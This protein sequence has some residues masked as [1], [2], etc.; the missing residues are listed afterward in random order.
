M[1]NILYGENESVSRSFQS[2]AAL[3]FAGAF[4]KSFIPA[5]NKK[6]LQS[7][8]SRKA[9]EYGFYRNVGNNKFLQNF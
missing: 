7:D 3:G 8:M 9:A 4:T 1:T 6:W 5:V 2:G